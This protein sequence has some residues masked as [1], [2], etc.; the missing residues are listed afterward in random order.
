MVLSEIRSTV[1]R[2]GLQ[3]KN[4]HHVVLM[5]A[6]NILHPIKLAANLRHPIHEF[7]YTSHKQ[8]AVDMREGVEYH[9]VEHNFLGRLVTL[10]VVTPD[11]F[12]RGFVP[13]VKQLFDRRYY[14]G[15]GRY[16]PQPFMLVNRTFVTD[17]FNQEEYIREVIDNH[18]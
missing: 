15:H 1:P 11:S 18:A 9:V 6:P 16:F 10:D 8:Y 5:L 2:E 14:Y 3:W 4:A 7:V 17:G 12:P 13:R